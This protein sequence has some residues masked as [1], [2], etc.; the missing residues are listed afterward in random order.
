M[1]LTFKS[2]LTYEQLEAVILNP[3]IMVAMCD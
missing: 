3:K 2:V 1:I